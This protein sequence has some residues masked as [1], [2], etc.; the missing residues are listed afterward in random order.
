MED[1]KKRA[2][3]GEEIQKAIR[4]AGLRPRDVA[5]LYRSN[6][7]AVEIEAALKERQIPLRMIGGQQFYERKEV[8]DLIA[9]LR[10]ALKPDDE[11]SMRRVINYPARGIGEAALTKLTNHATA[12]D[13]SLWAVV[14]RPHAVLELSPAAVEGCRGLVRIIEATRARFDQGKPCTEIARALCD[15][16]GLKED[17]V[18]ASSSNAAAARRWGNVEGIL[19]VFQRRDDKGKGDRESFADF[20]RVLA[21]REDEKEE[22]ADRVTLTTMHGAKGLEF[23]LV[24]VVGLEEGLLPH[25]RTVDERATDTAPAGAEAGHSLDEERRLFYVAVTRARDRLVLSRCKVRGLRGKPV[26]RVPSRFLQ[27]IP[28][29]LLDLREVLTQRLPDRAQSAAGAAAVLAALSKPGG[30]FGSK[31]SKP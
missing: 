14:L 18:A 8:K 5:V 12:Y 19:K 26:P 30:L 10:L 25:A 11:M 24:F 1:G 27:E 9:Y 15:D 6:L 17:I 4:E 13:Q 3:V 20:L 21:L 16:I 7:Q 28:E 22:A 2:E 29:E 23:K 31:G